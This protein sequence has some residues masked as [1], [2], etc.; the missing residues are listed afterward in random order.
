MTARTCFFRFAAGLYIVLGI[1]WCFD[2]CAT[3]R[4]QIVESPG[5]G[6]RRVGGTQCC[7]PGRRWGCDP[8]FYCLSDEVLGGFLPTCSPGTFDAACTPAACMAGGDGTD[9]GV[10]PAQAGVN[11]CM[12]T[13]DV[14]AC[15]DSQDNP[16]WACNSMIQTRWNDPNANQ[17]WTTL[18]LADCVFS[19]TYSICN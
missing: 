10:T 3:S 5:L 16:G 17:V 14:V 7:Q 8:A 2:L 4:Q 1:T 15:V 11:T 19:V 9:C 13:G 6:E 12:T 18:C